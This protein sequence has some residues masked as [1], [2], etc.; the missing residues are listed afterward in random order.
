[1]LLGAIVDAGAPA[2]ELSAVVEKLGLKNVHLHFERVERSHIGATKAHVEVLRQPGG[3]H[4]HRPLSAIL[5][6]MEGAPLSSRTRDC[7]VRVFRR[8]GEAE[9]RIHGVPVEQVHFHEIG[10]EDSIVDIV[11]SC[12]GLEILGVERLLCSPLDVGSGSVATE[13]GRLPVPAPA[14]AELLAGA[15]IFSSGVGMELVTPTGAALVSTL[16]A[17]FGPLPAMKLE[18]TGYGA[19]SRDLPDRPNVLRLFLGQ[20]AEDASPPQIVSVLEANVDDMNPQIAGFLAEK[21]LMH[22]ALDIYF[23][24]VQMKKGRPGLLLTVLAAPAD[25]ERLTRLLFEETSTIGVRSYRAERRS[26]DRAH[27]S[28]ETAYGPVRVKVSSSN[29]EVLNFAPE[30]DDCRR[31][32]EEKRVP[33]KRVL[34]EAAAE[35]LVRFGKK[36]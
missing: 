23:T 11:G 19:G 10:A 2:A 20:E 9:A 21:A 3:H 28:V 36:G 13:H 34:E 17:G 7:A 32:A 18:R 29:G 22:G 33:L 5:A 16:A 8:L 6:M 25:A 35:Y 12:A 15:P 31:L 26:L 1:M 14:T 4:H 27:V 30:Y 24:A